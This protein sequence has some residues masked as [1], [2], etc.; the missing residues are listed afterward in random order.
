MDWDISATPVADR[1]INSSTQACV[2]K[3]WQQNYLTEELS[4]FQ[5]G[6]GCHLSNKSVLQN[7]ALLEL[8]RS[9]V[10]A[11]IGKWKRLGATMDQPQSGRPHKLSAEAL[12]E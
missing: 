9:T 11:V 12:G 5:R 6:I 3:H 2:D 8:P 1:C 4:D 7:S 10:S